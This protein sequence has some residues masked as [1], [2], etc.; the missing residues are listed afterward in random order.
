MREI[1]SLRTGDSGTVTADA[2]QQLTSDGQLPPMGGIS[3]R[4]PRSPMNLRPLLV[5]AALIGC[6]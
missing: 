4:F 5:A 6:Q 1:R 3:F 2:R